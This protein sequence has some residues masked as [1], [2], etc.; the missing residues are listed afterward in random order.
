MSHIITLTKRR[1]WHLTVAVFACLVGCSADLEQAQQLSGATDVITMPGPLRRPPVLFNHQAHTTAL[2]TEGCQTCHPSDDNGVMSVL[3]GRTNN[4]SNP[5]ELMA[6]YHNTCVGC[7]SERSEHVAQACGECHQEQTIG[8]SAR[9]AMSFDYSLHSR[10]AGDDEDSCRECHHVYD[11]ETEQLVYVEDEESRC[12]ITGCHDGLT[13]TLSFSEAAHQACVNCHSTNLSANEETGPV[14]CV[15]CHD[16]HARADIEQLDEDEI[17]RI[18]IGQPDMVWIQVE[19]AEYRLVPFNH[20][21]IETQTETCSS[22]HHDGM[23]ACS[24]CHTLTGSDEGVGV[25]I[26]TAFHDSESEHSC[27][28]CHQQIVENEDCAGCHHGIE[29]V[30]GQRSCVT[31]HSGPFAGDP[32]AENPPP[33]PLPYDIGPLPATSDDFPE[34]IVLD[35]L[36]DDY[37]PVEFPHQ[38]IVEHLYAHTE[39]NQLAAHFHGNVEVLC[40]GCHH[41]TPSATR[42]PPCSSCHSEVGSRTTDFPDL[43]AAYHRQCMQCHEQM[44]IDE[45]GCTDCHE[46]NGL[47]GDR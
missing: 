5:N 34:T 20:A 23:S 25:T 8:D 26:F 10:H 18:D 38:Q 13:D 3:L 36:V 46:E 28:G 2:E 14:L 19:S 44:D 1:R 37:G 11:E 31:C 43:R 40:S 39:D 41:N 12:D 24:D 9:M 21:R 42:P 7:H 16:A 17:V 35:S 32:E 22:C 4:P 27:V 45:N 15:G 47:E 29:H 30:P 33:T 6:V